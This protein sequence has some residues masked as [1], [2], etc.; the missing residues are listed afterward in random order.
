M[1]GLCFWDSHLCFDPSGRGIFIKESSMVLARHQMDRDRHCGSRC[2]LFDAI[3][4]LAN[5]DDQTWVCEIHSGHDT[6]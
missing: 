5:R 1:E 3:H 6:G 2:D 4:H